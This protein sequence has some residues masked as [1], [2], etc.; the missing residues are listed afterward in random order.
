MPPPELHRPLSKSEKDILIRWVKQGAKYDPHWAFVTPQSHPTPSVADPSW[1]KDPLDAFIAQAATKKGLLPSAHADRATLLRRASFALTGLPPTIAEVDAFLADPSP[2]AYE[3]RVDALLAS[4]RYGE[5]LAVSW[6]DLSRYAD[7]WGY[8]GDKA[9]FAWPWRDW[10][11]KAF[12]ENKPYDPRTARGHGLQSD[13]S[14][15]LRGR[16]DRGRIPPGRHQRPRDDR[17]LR[18][19]GADDGVLPLSRP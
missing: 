18:F 9:M 1:P 3:K 5:H 7:T 12:N 15:D 8:T 19:H 11:L 16:L 2:E 13:P 4:P 6:L 17:R 10:V 14:H